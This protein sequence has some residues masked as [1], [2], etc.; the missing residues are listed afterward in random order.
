M[1][2]WIDYFAPIDGATYCDML[3]SYR[4]HKW[5]ADGKTW[6]MP[7]YYGD[8]KHGG[9]QPQYGDQQPQ[10][11]DQQPQYENTGGQYQ[12][13]DGGQ[14]QNNDG[15]RNQ[16][17]SGNG[18]NGDDYGNGNQNNGGQ[19]QNNAGYENGG[20]D[21]CGDQQYG[22]QPPLHGVQQQQYGD[23]QQ[24][25]NYYGYHGDLANDLGGSAKWYPADNG[26]EGDVRMYLSR[27]GSDDGSFE[28]GCCSNSSSDAFSGFEKAGFGKAFAMYYGP[29]PPTDTTTTITN[30]L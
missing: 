27:W 16:D 11:G 10:C 13:N 4:D 3:Q 18:N 15:G 5:S 30:I 21:Q 29:L 20:Y 8:D 24:Q 1:G 12:N 28:G 26:T 23:Q 9:Q 25:Y 14:Y 19:N 2:Y 17:Y 6:K 22:G 7:G